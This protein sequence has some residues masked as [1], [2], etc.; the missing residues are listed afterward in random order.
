MAENVTGNKVTHRGTRLWR[1]I[2][3]LPSLSCTSMVHWGAKCAAVKARPLANTRTHSHARTH[4]R[5]RAHLTPAW[6]GGRGDEGGQR[7]ARL[8]HATLDMI[9]GRSLGERR[10]FRDAAS[11]TSRRRRPAWSCDLLCGTITL[12]G[13]TFGD[14]VKLFHPGR[15]C[16]SIIKP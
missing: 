10:G 5:T 14:K 3:A 6:C 13:D 2:W 7:Q 1:D 12:F 15:P 4:A 11:P 9:R 8:L 16:F